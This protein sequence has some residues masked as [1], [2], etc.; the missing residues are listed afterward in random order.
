MESMATGGWSFADDA[1]SPEVFSAFCFS[2][3]AK[4]VSTE[5]RNTHGKCLIESAI[6]KYSLAFIFSE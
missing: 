6:R 1:E 2:P 4:N 5:K 3:Q